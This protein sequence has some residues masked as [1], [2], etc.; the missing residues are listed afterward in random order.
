MVMT[1]CDDYFALYRN[2]KSLCFVTETSRAL[3]VNY[4]SKTNKLIEKEIR[5]MVT[6]GG[7]GGRRI[8]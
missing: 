8:G 1:Y 2:V 5:Y 4:T 6:R 7:D 3:S